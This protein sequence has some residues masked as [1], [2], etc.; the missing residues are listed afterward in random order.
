MELINQYVL[1]GAVLLLA[2]RYHE[3]RHEPGAGQTMPFGVT[4][5]IERWRTVRVLGGGPA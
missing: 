2:A 5:L 4:A 1:A 3:F